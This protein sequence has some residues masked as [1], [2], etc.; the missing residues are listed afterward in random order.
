MKSTL[1]DNSFFFICQS[2]ECVWGS[3]ET[4]FFPFLRTQGAQPADVSSVLTI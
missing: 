4:V 3:L 2:Y 1:T